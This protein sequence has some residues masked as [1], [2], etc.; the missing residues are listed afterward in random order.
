MTYIIIRLIAVIEIIQ[1]LLCLAPIL[2]LLKPDSGMT[3]SGAFILVGFFFVFAGAGVFLWQDR[4]SGIWISFLIQF[5]QVFK[6]TTPEWE[7]KLII[8]PNYI[9]TIGQVGQYLIAVNVVTLV[10][11]MLL[12]LHSNKIRYD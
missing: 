11:C 9:I 3:F 10:F 2:L 1:G 4:L 8:G 7:Y 5:A 12:A 6:V